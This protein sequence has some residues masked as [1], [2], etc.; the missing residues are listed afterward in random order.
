M[1]GQ[2]RAGFGLVGWEPAKKFDGKEL[3]DA[4]S[5]QDDMLRRRLNARVYGFLLISNPR[6]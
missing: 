4:I 6:V 3:L 1:G 5:E 2:N